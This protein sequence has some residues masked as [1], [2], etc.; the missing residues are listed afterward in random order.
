MWLNLFVFAISIVLSIV[1]RPKAPEPARP[2]LE[3]LS[4]PKAEAGDPIPV[5]FGTV[6]ITGPNV[7]WY[8]DPGYEAVKSGGGGKGK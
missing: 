5:P 2:A 6:M 7:V 3:D 8:G 1:L 4:V